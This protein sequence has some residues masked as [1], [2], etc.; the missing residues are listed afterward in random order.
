[1]SDIDDFEKAFRSNNSN[2]IT[3]ELDETN[4]PEMC[5]SCDVAPVCQAINTFIA[6]EELGISMEV[7]NCRYY[8][9]YVG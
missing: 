1:M 9:R 4:I 8:R 6:F 3:E 7:T 2:E 5:K